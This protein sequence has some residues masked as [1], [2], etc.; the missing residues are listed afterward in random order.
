MVN[1]GNFDRY[2]VIQFRETKAIS[3]VI[4]IYDIYTAIK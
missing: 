4:I 1:L 2:I 3:V